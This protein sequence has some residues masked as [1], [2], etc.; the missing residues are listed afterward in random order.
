[1]DET[2]A[3]L[4]RTTVPFPEHARALLILTIAAGGEIE[5]R[6]EHLWGVPQYKLVVDEVTA[7]GVKTYRAVRA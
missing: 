3:E 6:D 4:N 5:I 7:T 2:T 1:M